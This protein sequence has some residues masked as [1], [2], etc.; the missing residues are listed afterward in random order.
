M[1]EV[2]AQSEMEAANATEALETKNTELASRMDEMERMLEDEV[3]AMD[4][5]V[6]ER[7]QASD[8]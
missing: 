1:E 5:M 7:T 6:E 4:E 3:L 8:D 2:L